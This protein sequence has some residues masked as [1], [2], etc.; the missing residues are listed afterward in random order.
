MK[1]PFPWF[2]GKSRAASLIWS[3]LGDCK[4]YIEPFTGSLAVLLNRPHWPF[5]STRIETVNDID[6]YVANFWRALKTDPDAV[7]IHADNPVNE[8]DLHAR[9][10]WL[11]RQS[12][13]VERL[14]TDPDYYDPR[15]AGY[16]CWGISSWIGYGF[17]HP[18]LPR[19][20]NGSVEIIGGVQD[21]HQCIL[22]YLHQLSDRLRGVRV[23]CGDWKRICTPCIT[24]RFGLCGILLDPPYDVECQPYG[25][26][27]RGLSA[28]VRKWAFTHGANPLL[29]IAMCGYTDERHGDHLPGWTAVKWR[30]PAGYARGK[31]RSRECIW[32]SPHCLPAPHARHRPATSLQK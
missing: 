28:E 7:A 15:I 13:R 11:H 10:V 19:L 16:W 21:R 18:R 24:E 25:I 1:A 6:V 4:N 31:N 3:R 22:S 8:A 9:H 30:P 5:Q 17:C 32:F 12:K 2:G 26:D 27:C 14:K 29:R 20:A 23:A